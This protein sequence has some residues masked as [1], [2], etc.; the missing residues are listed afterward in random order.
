MIVQVTLTSRR[1]N[2]WS[3]SLSPVLFPVVA[4]PVPWNS[5]EFLSRLPSEL[6]VSFPP[7]C[8]YAE[9]ARVLFTLNFPI[10]CWKGKNL[11]SHPWVREFT[12]SQYCL[13]SIKYSSSFECWYWFTYAFRYEFC[14]NKL[15]LNIQKSSFVILHPPRKKISGDFQLI[16]ENKCLNQEKC[17]KYLGVFIDS[18]LSWKSQ[19]QYIL[20]KIKRNVGILSKIRYYVDINVLS[21]LYYALIYPFWFME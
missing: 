7:C 21:N 18:S 11:S 5:D 14:S 4:D 13:S 20:T 6:R 10:C 1:L 12:Y 17:I 19:I 9:V 3:P 2:C 16:L 15:S 8:P